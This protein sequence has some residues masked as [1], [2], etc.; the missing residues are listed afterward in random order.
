MTGF[1]V[2]IRERQFRADPII[3]TG[4]VEQFGPYGYVY[5]ETPNPNGGGLI[6]GPVAPSDIV[7]FCAWEEG[8]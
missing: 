6:R 1:T 4:R 7:G 5:V 8:T 2:I 3:T